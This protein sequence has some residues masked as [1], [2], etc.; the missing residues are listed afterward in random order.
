MRRPATDHQIGVVA[1]ARHC[2]STVAAPD[3]HQPAAVRAAERLA[4]RA[5]AKRRY[6]F[7]S[8]HGAMRRLFASSLADEVAVR[9]AEAG[10]L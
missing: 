7:A 8:L 3:A 1:C 4:G 2:A 10:R 9:V 6:G 5:P